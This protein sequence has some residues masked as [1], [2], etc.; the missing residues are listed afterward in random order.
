MHSRSLSV[1]RD[2]A[3]NPG[4]IEEYLPMEPLDPMV[5]DRFCEDG[6]CYWSDLIFRRNYWEWRGEPC[7]VILLRIQLDGFQMSKSQRK[8]L[9]R[10]ADLRVLRR[11]LRIHRNHE[12]LFD[13]HA[14]RFHH[15]RPSTIYGFFSSWSHVMPCTG[16]EFD[17]FQQDRHIASSFFHMGHRSM[18]G[19]Y[20]IHDPEEAWRSLGTFTMLLEMEYARQLGKAYYYPGFVYDLPSEFDYKLNFHNLEY[21]DWWGN[22]YP[23]TRMPVRDWREDRAV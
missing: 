10:N 12:L 11:P 4:P 3:F 15:N 20:C 2:I 16:V 1:F 14:L 18:A 9:R 7:R 8:C 5:F 6:W 13:R 21:F 23:L 22:W 19:N 17:V